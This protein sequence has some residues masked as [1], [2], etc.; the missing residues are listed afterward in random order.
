[1]KKRAFTL[2]ELLVVIAIIAILAAILFPVFARARE[3]AR[4][5]TCL[6]NMKQIGLAISMY[7]QDYDEKFPAWS[8]QCAHDPFGNIVPPGKCGSDTEIAFFRWAILTQPYIKNAQMFL[9]PSY[10]DNFW[11]WGGWIYTDCYNPWPPAGFKGLSYDFKL[12]LAVAARCGRKLASIDKP[13]QTFV[14][15]ENSPVHAEKSVPF[16]SCTDPVSF[17]R[18]G[19][20]ATFVDGHARYILVGNHRFVKLRVWEV[21]PYPC[22]NFDPHWYVR[23]DRRNTWDP[24]EGW[25]V[26]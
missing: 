14:A 16:W 24:G 12:A 25:D 23:E 10:P 4:K 22:A 3:Q 17:T 26:D 6:S 20:N 19:M 5:T 2:I 13:A 18:M 7:L 11:K 15:Y 8:D 1:M 21:E 9:C